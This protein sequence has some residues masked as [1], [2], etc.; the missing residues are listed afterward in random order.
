M[1]DELIVLVVF[2]IP[3]NIN[4]CQ[5]WQHLDLNLYD[6][7]DSSLFP[8]IRTFI[9]CLPNDKIIDWPKFKAFVDKLITTQNFKFVQ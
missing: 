7:F 9:N 3:F 8:M 4:I 6:L 5:T 2:Y 1:I